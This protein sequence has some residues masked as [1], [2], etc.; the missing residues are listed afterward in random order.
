MTIAVTRTETNNARISERGH[1]TEWSV[2]IEPDQ[3]PH[4]IERL[5]AIQEEINSHQ[6]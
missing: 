1:L 6:S 2:E 5:Q 4:V 3:L